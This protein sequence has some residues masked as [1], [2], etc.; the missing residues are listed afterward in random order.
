MDAGYFADQLTG[1]I[2]DLNLQAESFEEERILGALLSAIRD[3]GKCQ[4][5]TEGR[6]FAFS[7]NKSTKRAIDC[8]DQE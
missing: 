7:F 5:K 8:E 2:T 1:R 3:G 6:V 4:V